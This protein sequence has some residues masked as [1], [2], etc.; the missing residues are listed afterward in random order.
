MLALTIRLCI[1]GFSM[2]TLFACSND[3]S[4]TMAGTASDPI[5]NVMLVCSGGLDKERRVFLEA[6]L[7][8]RSGILDS[9]YREL[10]R[11]AILAMVK[12]L[13]IPESDRAA[14]AIDIQRQYLECVGENLS[15]ALR[16]QEELEERLET[17]KCLAG[18]CDNFSCE[19][20]CPMTSFHGIP[21]P[22]GDGRSCNEYQTTVFDCRLTQ[23]GTTWCSWWPEQ[24]NYTALRSCMRSCQR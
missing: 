13:E 6:E 4:R 10:V 9:G 23:W 24:I 8:N 3:G 1:I 20:D 7:K 15:A 16:E 11:N 21:Y 2:V 12:D 19:D 17:V 14:A 18:C 5:G 22:S